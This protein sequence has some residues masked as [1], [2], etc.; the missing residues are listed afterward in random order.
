MYRI[1]IY[2]TG[3][4]LYYINLF[5]QRNILF[6][7]DSG[8]Q[9]SKYSL[10]NY[11]TDNVLCIANKFIE[12][13]SDNL[14]LVIISYGDIKN[15]L[16]YIY[17]LNPKVK[18]TIIEHYNTSMEFKA[19][20]A[21]ML[22]FIY[23]QSFSK[24]VLTVSP[25]EPLF[26]SPNTQIH[27]AL[28]YYSPFKKDSPIILKKNTVNYVITTSK[29]AALIDSQASLVPAKNYKI[30]GFPRNDYLI[31][32]KYDRSTVF[33]YLNL[34]FSI[35]YKIILYTPTHRTRDSDG[36]KD[37]I[38]GV[39]NIS[40][41]NDILIENNSILLIKYHSVD[42]GKDELQ[43]E[44]TS[45]IIFYNTSDLYSAYDILAHADIMLTDY[46]SMYFDFLILNR[47]V[48]FNFIDKDKYNQERG[49]SYD[50][51]ESICAGE[52]AYTENELLSIISNILKRNNHPN[53]DKYQNIKRLCNKYNDGNS[54]QRVYQFIKEILDEKSLASG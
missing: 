10:N 29:I 28:N 26:F 46:T 47:P 12:N 1:I 34:N 9:I 16:E 37:I 44:N 42:I 8:C 19:K 41:L 40:K 23:Y 4:L 17:K 38:M 43:K 14:H 33:E 3:Y 24:L 15:E 7:P 39:S 31:K 11:T 20:I 36:F 50:P 45:N 51:I 13:T 52:I 49:F 27:I 53:N 22:K 54:T 2:I 30:L 35:K 6:V 5:K 32:P 25:L 48:I 21:L 18:I